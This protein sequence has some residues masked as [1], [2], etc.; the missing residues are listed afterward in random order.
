MEDNFFKLA[1]V[2][3]PRNAEQKCLCVLCL[4]TSGSMSGSP[5]QSLNQGLKEF[6]DAVKN[7]PVARKRLEVAI[8]SFNSTVTTVQEP[9][10]VDFFQMPQLSATGST[11]LVSGVLEAIRKVEE[12]K[13]FYKKYGINYYRPFIILM[14]DGEPDGDQDLQKLKDAIKLG[15]E[16]KRFTFWAIGSEGFNEQKL[17]SICPDTSPPK[18]LAGVKYSEFF[19]W[20]SASLTM[21]SKS[22]QDQKITLPKTSDWEVL[23]L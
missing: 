12:R 16:E 4:D 3:E 7:D 21:V 14:T 17:R 20:L 19:Q 11:K 2:E 15:T 5:I 6:A 18:K 23:D 8:V 1:K 13:N 10:L 9:D 22:S